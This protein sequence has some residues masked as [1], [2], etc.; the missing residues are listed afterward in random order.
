MAA[1]AIEP[2][3]PSRARISL[4]RPLLSP[5]LEVHTFL[6]PFA[7]LYQILP[8]FVRSWYESARANSPRG[9]AGNRAMLVRIR[10]SQKSLSCLARGPAS[11][12]RF[13]LHTSR[14]TPGKTRGVPSLICTRVRRDSCDPGRNPRERNGGD[15]PR[16]ASRK[17]QPLSPASFS[18][19]RGTHLTVLTR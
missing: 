11:L 3:N 19:A 12:A 16:A 17:D 10:E 5:H 1:R 13:F 7:D 6:P 4:S 2:A 18:V 15:S 14:Q 8:G 9:S